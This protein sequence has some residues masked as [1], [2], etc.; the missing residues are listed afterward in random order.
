MLGNGK[1]DVS[2]GMYSREKVTLAKC[3]Y[4]EKV[5]LC[6]GVAVVNPVIAGVEQI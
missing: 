1:L 4:T 6:L 5:R 3:K 2:N